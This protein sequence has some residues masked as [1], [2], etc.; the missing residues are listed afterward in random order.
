[1]LKIIPAKTKEDI[2]IAKQLFTE[3]A[4]F[5]KKELC[6]YADLPWLIQYYQN[7]EEEINNLPDQYKHPKGSILLAKYNKQPVGCVGLTE[8]SEGVCEMKRLFVRT[9]HQRKGLGT[10]ICKALMEYAK[11]IGYTHMR[12]ATALKIPKA[13]YSS[14]GF[15]VIKPYRDTPEEIKDIAFMELRLM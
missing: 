4:E 5:L 13:L 8:Q 10:A 6:E 7:F 2:K 3:Y 9:K 12:L 1:M 11:K 14:L 15:K